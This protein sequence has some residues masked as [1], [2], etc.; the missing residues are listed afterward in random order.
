MKLALFDL[1]DTLIDGDCA[2]LWGRYMLELGWVSDP[3]FV[4]TEQDM[5]R[6]YGTGALSMDDYMRFTL[7]PLAG[8]T[9]D[10]VATGVARFIDEAILPVVR[11]A[12][13]RRVREH[14]E[15]G[16]RVIVISAS[17]AHLVEPIALG[18]G[19]RETL[20]IDLE[21]REG[22][23]T[24]RTQGILTFREGKVARLN[25]LLGDETQALAGA[26]FYSDSANDLPLLQRVGF[27]HAVNPDDILLRHA[28]QA[29]WPVLD[30]R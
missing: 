26:S 6:E 5:M 15:R 9:P 7:A 11:P 3:Q 24:G 2:S 20:C 29:G 1:D 23:Y 21:V 27:P 13:L 8:R 28:R 10:E 30:W 16:E 19:I 25:H 22:R 12:A 17:G 14:Q 4:R 18:F